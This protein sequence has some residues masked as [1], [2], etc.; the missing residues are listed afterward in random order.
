[1][2]SHQQNQN[3]QYHKKYD[4]QEIMEPTCLHYQYHGTESG[5]VAKAYF[6]A[7]GQLRI[8]I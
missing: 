6:V 7:I 3:N 1:M 5:D 2:L 8:S 4:V